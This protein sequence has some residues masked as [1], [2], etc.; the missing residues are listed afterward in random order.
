MR[1][2][3]LY[4][5][6]LLVFA[7]ACT[8][9]RFDADVSGIEANVD[10]KRLDQDLFR[11]NSLSD[12]AV[13]DS[14]RQV[15]GSFF[16][17]YNKQIIGIGG[18]DQQAYPNHLMTFITDFRVKM[19]RQK[20]QEVFPEVTDLE[21][22]LTQAFKHYKYYFPNKPVP[23][24]Y[25]MIT[26]FSYSVV[27]DSAVVG[28]G[29]D[30]YLGRGYYFYGRLNWPEYLRYKMFEEKIPSDVMQAY[31][32]MEFPYN[33]STDNLINRMIYQG[34]IKYFTKAMLPRQPD[35]LIFAYS[36]KEMEWSIDNE[37]YIW[38]YFIEKKLLFSQKQMIYK[39]YLEDAPFTTSFTKKAPPRL[40]VWLGYRI[41]QK[42]MKDH[43]EVSLADLMHIG[44]YRSVLNN[45]AYDP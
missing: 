14:L 35:S 19:A 45:A 34:S 23:D 3:I 42:Y 16:K 7:Q 41:V 24:I 5:F 37:S 28:I 2:F 11:F 44:H 21:E 29:L 32:M 31:A 18:I 10:I 20:T 6:L 4:V 15:Y 40:G 36:K 9:D 1:R 22:K 38:S 25:S 33:D 39:K 13:I 30:R 27:T 26:G 17:L 43:P 8:Q 12:T